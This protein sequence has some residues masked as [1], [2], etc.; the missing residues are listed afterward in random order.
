MEASRLCFEDKVHTSPE[1]HLR[2][3]LR[4][5][6][7]VLFVVT[8]CAEQPKTHIAIRCAFSSVGLDCD[9]IVRSMMHMLLELLEAEHVCLVIIP[10]FNKPP[11]QPLPKVLRMAIW[12]G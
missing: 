12:N 11:A 9:H 1:E 7:A 10:L 3:A 2:A 6:S 5:N 4:E 8:Q